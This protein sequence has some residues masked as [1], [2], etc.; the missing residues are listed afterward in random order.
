MRTVQCT[1]LNVLA[2]AGLLVMLALPAF[3]QL[4]VNNNGLVGIKTN[5]PDYELDVVGA[6]RIKTNSDAKLLFTNGDNQTS[7]LQ[8]D[9]NTNGFEFRIGNT[10]STDMFVH[11]NGRVGLGTTSP[12]TRLEVAQGNAIKLGNAYLSSGGS[13]WAHL[14]ANAW[15]D[16]ANWQIPDGGRTSGILQMHNNTLTFWN[17]NS[18]GTSSWSNRLAIASNGNVGIGRSNPSYKLDVNGSVRLNNIIYNSDGRFKANVAALTSSLAAISSLRGVSYDFKQTQADYA[19]GAEKHIGFIAQEVQQVFPE[20][21]HPDADGYL[22]VDYVALIP[23]L[24]EAMKEQQA[25]IKAL[26]ARLNE[27]N[28][29]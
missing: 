10:G 9:Y 16:G 18:N 20:L 4:K 23:V 12:S 21:V 2:L 29:R 1:I 8:Y 6:A 26:E 28:A 11:N 14:G 27:L 24:V 22:G 19:F 5:N 25:Q 3:G 13:A 17:T 15:F 7:S